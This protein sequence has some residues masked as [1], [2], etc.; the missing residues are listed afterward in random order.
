MKKFPRR[1]VVD[2][3]AMIC[4]PEPTIAQA[5]NGDPLPVIALI[6][7]A[8]E[9]QPTQTHTSIGED[10]KVLAVGPRELQLYLVRV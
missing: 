5:M 9:R 10:D 8:D 3:D 7:E 6:T 1:F 2:L 4:E